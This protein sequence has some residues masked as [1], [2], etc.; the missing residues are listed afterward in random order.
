MNNLETEDITALLE[1]LKDSGFDELHI[2]T[3]HFEVWVARRGVASRRLGRPS[4]ARSA[5]GPTEPDPAPES[6]PPPAADR[7]RERASPA[8]N[9]VAAKSGSSARPITAPLMGTFYRA[10]SPGAAPFVEVGQEVTPETIIGIIEVMKLM[11]QIP[12]GVAGVIESI[13]AADA[14]LIEFGQPIMFAVNEGTQ[15]S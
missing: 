15:E 4:T 12:A 5:E 9:A 2:E 10:P 13:V 14:T 7:V 8:A 1:L 3:D 6:T 11:N